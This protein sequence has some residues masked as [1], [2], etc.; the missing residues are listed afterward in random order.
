MK[1]KMS[2][3]VILLF[4]Q[5]TFG[6]TVATFAGFTGSFGVFC[7][8]TDGAGSVA[9]F[10]GP[11]GVTVDASGNVYVADSS[12]HTIRKITPAGVVSTFAGEAGTIG[13]KNNTNIY[14]P[15]NFD[16]P[17]G[18][19][20]DAFGNVYVADTDNNLIRKITTTGW[21]S[22]FAGSGTVG[23]TDGIGSDA[24]FNS[25]TGVAIDAF[26]NVYVADY[27]NHTIRKITAAGEVSTF[28]GSAGIL[29]STDGTGTNARFY[30]PSGVAVDALGNVY[31]ADTSNSTIR[32]ITSTGVVTTLAGSAGTYGSSNGTGANARF[33]GPNG[34][35]VDAS[36]NVYVADSFN[37]TIRK[38]TLAGVVSTLAGSAG[39][40]GST[41]GIGTTARF[42]VPQ[43]VVVD[44][45]GNM[46]VADTGNS[47]IRKITGISLGNANFEIAM[48]LK[49]YPN[50]V[51]ELLQ[52]QTPNNTILDKVSI[53]DLTG[54]KVLEQIQ[55]T[56]QVD[57]AHLA[58]GMYII[59]AFAGKE[60]FSSKFIKE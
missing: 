39:T 4:S 3:L 20:V 51:T 12:N 8:T 13:N 60:K 17:Q 43:G 35:A 48:K 46:Y 45:S 41:D 15:A 7:G 33:K 40:S 22:Y 54:K 2:S 27:N 37:Q 5:F 14:S 32:K 28:A 25:P 52:I 44:A 50:P 26:G 10:C 59:E 16:H 36:G 21:V 6:Q 55:N 30:F 58:N 29:G 24:R 19:A 49:I 34:V 23:S 9:R 53:V 1:L 31:V 47:R 42:Y 56:S 11:G 38:I 18:V 57:V